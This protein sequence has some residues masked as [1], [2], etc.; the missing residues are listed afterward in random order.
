[1]AVL[2]QHKFRL[3]AGFYRLIE[4]SIHEESEFR[5]K[6]DI[7][8]M[9]ELVAISFLINAEEALWKSTAILLN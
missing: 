4:T 8:T 5:S 9:E 1:M 6:D 3:N 2:I 7:R